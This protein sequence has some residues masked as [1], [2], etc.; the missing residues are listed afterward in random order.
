MA[1]ALLITNPVAARTTDRTLGRIERVFRDAGWHVDVRVTTAHG[2]ANRFAH[3]GLASGV[4]V[5]TVFGGDG[6]TMQAAAALVGTDVPLG[7][8]PG[9]TGNLLAANLGLPANPVAAA[10]VIIAGAPGRID[11]GRLENSAGLRYFA[12]AAGAGI[13]ARVMIET[14]AAMKRR[15]GTMAYVAKTMQLL[16][17]VRSHQFRITVDGVVQEMEAA[18][19]LVANCGMI[20]PPILSLGDHVSPVDGIF[21]IVIVQAR[22][23]AGGVRAVWDLLRDA[24]GTYGKD[25]FI[26]RHRGKEVAVEVI[27]GVQLVQTDGDAGGE[28]PFTI[29]MLPMALQVL[30]AAR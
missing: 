24:K 21:D 2:D 1:R 27:G 8:L 10:K 26:A 15:W 16:P 28:T 6:T 14:S 29:T 7:L 5:V 30:Q 12:V 25:V 13:D 19:M 23:V 4:E 11:L 3:E 17:N 22:S 20:I 9:G 18:M